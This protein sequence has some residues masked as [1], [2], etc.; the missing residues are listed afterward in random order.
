MSARRQGELLGSG[1]RMSG[2]NQ[3]VPL[4]CHDSHSRLDSRDNLDGAIDNDS[5][6]DDEEV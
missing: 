2:E 5:D 6:Q 4:S 1:N 3:K